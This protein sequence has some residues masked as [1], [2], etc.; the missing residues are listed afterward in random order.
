MIKTEFVISKANS[1]DLDPS[2]DPAATV[3]LELKPRAEGLKEHVDRVR[4]LLR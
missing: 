4:V 3:A 2:A 1:R